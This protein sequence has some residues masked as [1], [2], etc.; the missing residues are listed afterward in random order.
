METITIIR[1]VCAPC[2]RSVIDTAS[3]PNR[4]MPKI[5]A[6]MT[7]MDEMPAPAIAKAGWHRAASHNS[8]G[9][10]MMVELKVS[11]DLAGWDQAYR[12]A[13]KRMTSPASASAVSP[14]DGGWRL[15]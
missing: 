5:V 13:R 6:Q 8:G 1:I 12:L 9:N 15:S 14:R 3:S 7:A 11:H 10:V 2:T 4:P